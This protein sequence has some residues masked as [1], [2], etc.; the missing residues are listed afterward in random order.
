MPGAP[1]D[2]EE[3]EQGRCNAG[4]LGWDVDL[5]CVGA[6]VTQRCNTQVKGPRKELQFVI[7]MTKETEVLLQKRLRLGAPGWLNKVSV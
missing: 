6:Y 1:L 5:S 2:T 4:P 3:S 7:K